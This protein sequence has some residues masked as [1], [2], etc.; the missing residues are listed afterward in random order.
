MV[1]RI[2]RYGLAALVC[3]LAFAQDPQR[4]TFEVASVRPSPPVPA[5]GG[6][7]FGPPRGG[8]G[9][10]DPEHITWT[11]ATL[12]A[13]L[14]TAYD[15]KAYQLNAPAWLDTERYDIA[16]KVPAGTTA[17][18]VRVMWQRLLAERFG[19]ALHR[20]SKEFKV[21]ELSV[22]KDG[23]KLKETTWDSATRVPAGPPRIDKGELTSPGQVLGI[24]PGDNGMAKVHMVGKAQPIS[25]L[26]NAIGN[27]LNR[28]VL[29][30]TGLNGRYDYVVDY[31]LPIPGPGAAGAGAPGV[32]N[33]AG[34]DLATAVQQQLGLRLTRG[35]ATLDVLVIDKV[36]KTPSEN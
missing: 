17:E 19:V 34:I 13:M 11:Y 15:V 2:G 8:P 25:Q 28:P 16:A 22:A 18:Q 20:E 23:S 10:P 27:S 6:V 26:T 24:V 31:S 7:Y 12:K 14:L 3:V 5:N 35:K 32:A 21:E 36:E 30:K 4:A 29:D 9:T 33:E 1:Q